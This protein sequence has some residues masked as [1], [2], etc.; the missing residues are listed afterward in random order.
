M[1]RRRRLLDYY[2]QFEELSPEEDRAQYRRMSEEARSEALL[3][4]PELDLTSTA[5]HEAPHPEVVNAATYALRRSVNA[6]P[7]PSAH[8]VRVALGRHHGLDPERVVVSHGAGELLGLALAVLGAGGGEVLLP[9]PTW[10]PLAVLA[11]RGGA[12][13]VPVPLRG[14]AIDLA[15][16]DAA[17]RTSTRAIVL[18]SPND[19]TGLPL[20]RAEL[21]AFLRGLPERV[22]VLLDEAC[23]D[24]LEPDASALAEP[25]RHP[26][27]SSCAPSPRRTPWRASGSAGRRAARER[28]SC[29]A[30]WP[31]AGRSEPSRKPG[32]SPPSTW[33]TGSC[34][35]GGRRPPPTARGC[36]PGSRARGPASRTAPPPTSRGC[37]PRAS[38]PARSRATSPPGASS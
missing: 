7:D 37:A 15:A 29:W 5:W 35:A 27:S 36:G 13:P 4:V 8:A 1:R 28:P 10:P 22:V 33:P 17:V 9:W 16:L 30:R 34:R 38:T 11:A 25:P 14:D 32:R 19:P 12:T 26:G 24:L 23:A 3:V 6:Y 18:A 20:A 21:R 2:R 31:R